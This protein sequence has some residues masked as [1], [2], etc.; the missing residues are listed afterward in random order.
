M[1]AAAQT[2]ATVVRCP[3]CGQRIDAPGAARCPLCK[4]PLPVTGDERITG[5]DVTPYAKAYADGEA[6]W[7][8]MCRWVWSAST[9]R[10]KHLALMRS[11]AASRTFA[12]HTSL[13]LALGM[14]VSQGTR[15]GWFRVLRAGGEVKP[16]GRGWLLVGESS[17]S[18]VPGFAA[19]LWWNPAQAMIGAVIAGLSG[20]L[21]LWVLRH[22]VG[23]GIGLS[24]QRPYRG[25]RRMS[26]ALLYSAAWGVP[27]LM[28]A[29]LCLLRPFAWVGEVVRW[30][31]TPAD[32]TVRML[33]GT[34]AAL[35]AVFWWI[36]LVRLGS[37]APQATRMR[38][39]AFFLLGAPVIAAGAAAGWWFGL[40][41]LFEKLFF[42]L[43][44]HF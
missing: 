37:T 19:D 35:S 38:V 33:A 7:W 17:R 20:L 4:F 12:L 1:T 29:A 28:G 6:G 9:E 31:W 16:A 24:H 21:I 22:V 15:V 2:D 10:L 43:N 8:A 40:E 23:A 44:M 32:H 30:S 26:A 27:A 39:M 18:S 41:W 25:E 14:T 42:R 13:L 5:A 11:S 36:W 3:A 34:I